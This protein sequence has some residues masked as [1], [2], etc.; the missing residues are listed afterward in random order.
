[1]CIGNA[2]H[3]LHPVAGQ[4]FNLGLRDLTVL[5]KVIA[6]SQQIGAFPMLNHYWKYRKEDHNKTILMT[7]SLVR[8]FSNQYPLLSI[9][10]NI[11][12]QIMS[13]FPSLSQ[14]IIKQA[15]GQFDLFNRENLS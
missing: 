15:K 6:E 8:I 1:V 14:P 2:A 10:R 12:L 5:A 3:N 4:G 13:L 11:G 9:P 7:D